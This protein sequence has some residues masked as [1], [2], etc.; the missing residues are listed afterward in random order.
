M[1]E[2]PEKGWACLVVLAEL[3]VSV[4]PSLINPRHLSQFNM[5]NPPS[6]PPSL[7][8]FHIISLSLYRVLR[9]SHTWKPA[10][11]MPV[12]GTSFSTKTRRE[13]RLPD[14]TN[15]HTKN[16][17]R[18]II[19]PTSSHC[20]GQSGSLKV[21]EW[22]LVFSSGCLSAADSVLRESAKHTDLSCVYVCV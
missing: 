22:S 19:T 4:T 1:N 15:E 20:M 3:C 11:L 6:S 18:H 12:R 7:S 8:P 9:S 5:D 16:T 10:W 13:E 21:R 2:T 14:K 17:H